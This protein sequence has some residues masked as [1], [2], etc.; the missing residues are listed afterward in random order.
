MSSTGTKRTRATTSTA[1]INDAVLPVDT[2]RST[3]TRR[4]AASETVSK[5]EA[6]T[7][8]NDVTDTAACNPS[9]RTKRAASEDDLSSTDDDEAKAKV[10]D[11]IAAAVAAATSAAVA[12]AT[13]DSNSGTTMQCREGRF[14]YIRSCAMVTK[15]PYYHPFQ[16]SSFSFT[17]I[18]HSMRRPWRPPG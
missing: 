3:R 10:P 6:N 2:R 7:E 9:K 17:I 13:S 16:G 1:T 11:G 18:A 8:T 4:R 15:L 14:V 12:A 5:A